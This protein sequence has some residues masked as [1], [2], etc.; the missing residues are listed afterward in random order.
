MAINLHPRS[1]VERVPPE[2]VEPLSAAINGD[3]PL[4][5]VVSEAGKRVSEAE[6]WANYY[7]HPD[8]A[9]EWNDGILEERP[10]SDA[11]NIA[12]YAWLLTLVRL[13]LDTNPI[14]RLL[15]LEFGFRLRLRPKTTIR[16][17]DF[18]VVLNDNPVQLQEDD[19]S[20][21]GIIDLAVECLSDLTL[22][23]IRLDTVTKKA[24][25]A[26]VGVREYY[27]LDARGE[28]MA[29]YQRTA[30]GDYTDIAP[31]AEAVI[32]SQVLPGFQFRIS[33]L[34]R[35]PDI[36]EMAEDPIYQDFVLPDYQI[37][38]RRAEQERMRADQQQTR[39][40][41]H[42]RLQNGLQ[43]EI[44][45][46]GPNVPVASR[47]QTPAVCCLQMHWRLLE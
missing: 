11:R 6:Y 44:I 8:F 38:K 47:T 30:S 40:R 34:H 32:R 42:H 39:R 26:R 41:Q 29:F 5:E 13:Y 1:T 14:G 23:D 36:L 25:Y 37:A 24:E 9:Y 12:I 2:T 19:H 16:K 22:K 15:L 46:H 17:P 31:S 28:H 35:Q 21:K 3:D 20:F 27:I 10:V 18:A 45:N 4:D 43:P 33:D 7:E